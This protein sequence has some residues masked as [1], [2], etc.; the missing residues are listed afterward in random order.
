ME[1]RMTTTRF[2]HHHKTSQQKHK[3]GTRG[4][5]YELHLPKQWYLFGLA[6]I[7]ISTRPLD[8]TKMD[9]KC[10]R[11]ILVADKPPTWHPKKGKSRKVSKKLSWD[12]R[13]T[14]K[15]YPSLANSYVTMETTHVLQIT[16]YPN[17]PFRYLHL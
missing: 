8:S 9:Q 17:N 10:A 14:W 4:I 2:L 11:Q 6:L 1:Y 7:T 5:K 3:I 15:I 12:P 16:S 13:E